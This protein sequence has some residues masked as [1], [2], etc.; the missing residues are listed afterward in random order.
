MQS[1]GAITN[2]PFEIERMKDQGEPL[3]AQFIVKI[4]RKLKLSLSVKLV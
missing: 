1:Y 3:N 2:G 4:Q